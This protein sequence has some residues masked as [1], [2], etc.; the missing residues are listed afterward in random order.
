MSIAGT[1]KNI[2]IRFLEKKFG[3]N[4][5]RYIYKNQRGTD[6]LIVIF[7]GFSGAGVPARYNYMR[8][9]SDIKCSKLFI[10]DDFGYQNRGGYY[11][12]D[13][14]GK[15]NGTIINE[16]SSLIAEY[17]KNRKIVTVGSS[18]GGTAALLYGVLCGADITISGAPQYY[19]GN[20]LNCDSHI[21]ILKSIYGDSGKEAVDALNNVLPYAIKENSKN[22]LPKVFIHCSKNEHTYKEHVEDMV[23]DLVDNG[24]VVIKDIDYSYTEHQDVA[25]FF[26]QYLISVLKDTLKNT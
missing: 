11:L 22:K 9:L 2:Y 15:Y 26:P 3:K 8:T 18:K 21:E 24:Y 16:I 6:T 1:L 12:V 20:Y 5:V 25:K 13:R 19:I 7:S 17:A 23:K 4:K 14:N 10:L